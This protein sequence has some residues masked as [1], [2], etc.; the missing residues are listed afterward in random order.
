[1]M[2]YGDQLVSVHA[3]K[4]VPLDC[5]AVFCDSKGVVSWVG[6][7]FDPGEYVPLVNPYTF[8]RIR[9]YENG[10]VFQGYAGVEVGVAPK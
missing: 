4:K 3:V 10:E 1:M 2:L 8:E 9:V 7:Y 5:W 6:E